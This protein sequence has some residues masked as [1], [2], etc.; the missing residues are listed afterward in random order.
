M[1][2]QDDSNDPSEPEFLYGEAVP[3]GE[4][5]A[6]SYVLLDQGTPLEFGIALS[7]DALG[8]LPTTGMMHS[9][10]LPA[11]NP[12]SIRLVELDW[13]PMGH[14]PPAI[15][16]VPH[17]DFHFYTVTQAERD[18]IDPADPD[19]QAKAA[20]LP[21]EDFRAPGYV[22]EP[23]G[24]PRMGVHWNN[25]TFPEFNGQPFTRT[26]IYGS[27]DGKPTLL[28]PMVTV[29]FLRSQPA[30]RVDIPVASRHDAVGYYPGRYLVSWDETATFYA[31]T[32]RPGR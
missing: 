15:Y 12:T 28:E 27:W 5:E 6:R 16:T 31:S 24:V 17:F 19:F 26:F 1:V 4:G 3:V 2:W 22:A 8:G 10:L 11:T 9:F 32:P 21:A 20:N 30:D 13:N 23:V 7:E 25:P 14:P 18:A 29:D